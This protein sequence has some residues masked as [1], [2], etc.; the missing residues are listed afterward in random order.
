MIIGITDPMRDEAT[1]AQ[2]AALL[3]RWVPGVETQRLS[4]RTGTFLEIERCEAL[5]MAGG[6][7]IHP[8]FYG[9]EEDAGLA[10][11]VS[12]ARDLFEFDIIRE[13]MER[14]LP[15]LGICRGAQILNVAM[16]GTLLPDIEAA[17][18]PSHRRGDEGERVHGV[19]VAAG[20]LLRNIVEKEK[21][22]VNT[23]HHQ[24]AEKVGRGLRVAAVSDDGIVEAMEWEEP[25]EKPFL[26]LVQWHP[27]RMGDT[28][29]P[30]SRQIIQRFAGAVKSAYVQK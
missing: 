22:E 6:G 13:A 1:Y 26:L 29:S 7:D 11:E 23:S 10:K 2:Y 3:Q 9:R 27:E 8:K 17:G 24:A 4:C 28:D 19:T 20:S 30:F 18:H 14:G 15:T 25:W 12:V 21:G 5:V 16:G